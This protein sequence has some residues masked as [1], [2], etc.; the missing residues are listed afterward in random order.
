MNKE[1][2]DRY[3]LI[4]GAEYR[5]AVE[6]DK[7]SAI[8]NHLSAINELLDDVDQESM[9]KESSGGKRRNAELMTEAVPGN[10]VWIQ[11]RYKEDYGYAEYI[12]S[13]ASDTMACFEGCG[14]AVFMPVS[15][16]CIEWRLWTRKPTP[17]EMRKPWLN[18]KKVETD[19]DWDSVPGKADV[20]RR[21]C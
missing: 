3:S 9:R 11:C 17:E 12:G 7:V 8:R 14:S 10:V 4:T 13:T 5:D 2:R 20:K 6:D 1:T 19:G 16:F 21:E 15:D 18:R